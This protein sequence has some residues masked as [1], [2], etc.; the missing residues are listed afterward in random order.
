MGVSL[1]SVHCEAQ[2]LRVRGAIV[3]AR[4]V[5]ESEHYQLLQLAL[6][7]HRMHGIAAFS[8][9]DQLLWQALADPLAETG[10]AD[11]ISGHLRLFP[12]RDITGLDLAAPDVDHQVE[13]QP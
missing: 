11:E 2:R 8:M 6:E 12:I 3:S 5:E 13:L 1:A 10:A 9:Q 4:Y 7:H